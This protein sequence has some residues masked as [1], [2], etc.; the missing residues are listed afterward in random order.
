MIQADGSQVTVTVGSAG[1]PDG[2]QHFIEW[3]ALETKEGVQIK[4]LTPGSNSVGS[5][6]QRG[7]RLRLRNLHG[8]WKA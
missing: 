4:H 2:P 7:F 3:I 6:R 1:A 8:L 5:G